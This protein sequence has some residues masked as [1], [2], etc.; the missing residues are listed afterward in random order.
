[1]NPSAKPNE[2]HSSE[3][4]SSENLEKSEA[5]SELSRRRF[6]Q[7]G[8]IGG[9][10]SLMSAGSIN[11]LASQRLEAQTPL[12]PDGALKALMDGNERFASGQM[13]SF[14]HDLKELKAANVDKQEP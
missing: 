9:T 1:M 10:A 2:S 6:L 11:F 14:E 7:T 4:L 5:S 12:T 8:L 13:T 3:P